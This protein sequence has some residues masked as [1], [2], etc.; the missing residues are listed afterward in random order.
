MF[1]VERS[2]G[3]D[4]RAVDGEAATAGCLLM[5]YLFLLL[6]LFSNICFAQNPLD[7]HWKIGDLIFQDLDCGPLCDAI[8]AVTK[9]AGGK[10]F[11]H[12]GLVY[13]RNDLV[14][15]IEAIGKDVHLTPL[16]DFIKRSKDAS[17]HY[18]IVA[19]RLKPRYEYLNTRAIKFAL[20]Q[21]GTPYDDVFLYGNG[22]YYCSELIYDAYKDANHGKPFFPLAPMTFKD[23]STGKTF[24]AWQDYYS[25][26]HTAIP[27]GQPGCNPGGISSSD[28]I[29]ILKSFY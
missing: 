2:H 10:K 29:E 7:F 8:E 28:K 6:L 1:S 5:R 13:K 24:P 4:K 25:K 17:G 12:I 18:K 21:M 26:L 3:N 19:G 16:K 20:K 9:G 27:E 11:S 14:Y 22:K 23:P 15:V